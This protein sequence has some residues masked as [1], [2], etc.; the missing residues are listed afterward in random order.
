M[1][2]KLLNPIAAILIRAGPRMW[3]CAWPPTEK[4]PLE[5]CIVGCLCQSRCS[6]KV[7][8]VENIWPPKRLFR[9]QIFS[10]YFAHGPAWWWQL[11]QQNY[12][13]LGGN[14][15]GRIVHFPVLREIPVILRENRK[16][17][18]NSGIATKRRCWRHFDIDVSN[19]DIGIVEYRS[20]TIS[21][22]LCY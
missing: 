19:P 12:I 6:H 7:H 14:I 22:L 18:E 9:G 16:L 17:A 1:T 11:L 3:A 2:I 21:K 4:A 20:A 13:R 15:T 10:T 5:Y 8:H